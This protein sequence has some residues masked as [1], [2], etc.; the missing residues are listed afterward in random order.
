MPAAR[1]LRR[2]RRRLERLGG[3]EVDVPPRHETGRVVR[4]VLQRGALLVLALP[5]AAL[6]AAAWCLPYL[7]SGLAARLLRPPSETVATV[8]FLAGE[9]SYPV[10]YVGWIV[11]AAW[12]GGALA[13]ILAALAL[14]LL[15]FAALGWGERRVEVWEDMK[16]LFQ[17]LRRPKLRDRALAQRE[18]LAV[19]L[20]AIE[21]DWQAKGA[22]RTAAREAAS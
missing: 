6:G 16:L 18:A 22:G 19:A 8:K 14:P 5:L 2:Y 11:L 17:I 3:G 7:F 9:V 13:A 21:A 1:S 12:L 15:G 10:T 4:D 20:D